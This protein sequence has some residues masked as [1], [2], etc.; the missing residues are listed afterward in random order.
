MTRCVNVR[1][2]LESE[3]PLS[4]QSHSEFCRYHHKMYISVVS[5]W[6]TYFP[7]SNSCSHFWTHLDRLTTKSLKCDSEEQ[8]HSLCHMVVCESDIQTSTEWFEILS[9]VCRYMCAVTHHD[10]PNLTFCFFGTQCNPAIIKKD[11]SVLFYAVKL[12]GDQRL[13]N[14]IKVIPKSSENVPHI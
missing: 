11:H 1:V 8:C 6:H 10:I 7:Q 13:Q 2:Q 12:I 5:L 4:F 9:N 14:S 3:V